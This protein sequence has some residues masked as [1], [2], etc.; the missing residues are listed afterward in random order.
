MPQLLREGRASDRAASAFGGNA[1]H[2]YVRHAPLL[3]RLLRFGLVGLFVTGGYAV[4]TYAAIRWLHALPLYASLLGCVVAIIVSYLGQKYFTFRSEGAHRIELPKFL[5]ACTV[6]VV[7]S[8]ASM[9]AVT[10]ARLDYRLGILISALVLPLCNFTVMHLW[11]FA[12]A[13]KPVGESSRHD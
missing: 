5:L 1:R 4:S 11:V 10:H 3:G 7:G 12:H 6:A 8:S 13:R 9:I 2:L